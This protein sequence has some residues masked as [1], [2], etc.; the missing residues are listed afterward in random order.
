[1]LLIVGNLSRFGGIFQVFIASFNLLYNM[2]FLFFFTIHFSAKMHGD[3]S[4]KCG[5][6]Y[7]YYGSALLDLAR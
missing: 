2:F 3:T 4:D 7:F 1:M 5:E 6:A